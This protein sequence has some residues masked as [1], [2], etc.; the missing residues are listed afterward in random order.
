M[1]CAQPP[2]DHQL[3]LTLVCHTPLIGFASWRSHSW[4]LSLRGV[5]RLTSGAHV[6][7]CVVNSI[8]QP[9]CISAPGLETHHTV[10]DASYTNCYGRG[11]LLLA[12]IDLTPGEP[13]KEVKI[14]AGACKR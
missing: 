1:Q 9:V 13:L 10:T 8:W 7:N 11:L 2:A 3:G 12:H 4:L 5:W 14:A 6:V